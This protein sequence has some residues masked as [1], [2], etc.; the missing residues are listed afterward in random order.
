MDS[1]FWLF[2]QLTGVIVAF[3]VIKLAWDFLALG[4]KMA[5]NGILAPKEPKKREPNTWYDGRK[6]KASDFRI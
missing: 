5:V 3:S 1:M 2:W 6:V 4:S